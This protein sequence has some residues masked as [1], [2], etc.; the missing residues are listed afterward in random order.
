MATA[1]GEEVYRQGESV[2]I[3]ASAGIFVPDT[4]IAGAFALPYTLRNDTGDCAAVLRLS[5]YFVPFEGGA[6]PAAPSGPERGCGE[7]K[8]LLVTATDYPWPA[9]PPAELPVRLFIERLSWEHPTGWHGEP[10]FPGP[11]ALAVESGTFSFWVGGE[12]GMTPDISADVPV[13]GQVVIKAGAPL[14]VWGDEATAI[15]VVGIAPAG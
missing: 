12:S 2:F 9:D 7:Y 14:A 3:P 4:G 15:L 5:V 8:L 11:V 6:T 10:F 1:D 13:G